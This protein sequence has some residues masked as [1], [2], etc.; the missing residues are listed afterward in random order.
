MGASCAC[1]CGERVSHKGAYRK[2]HQPAGTPRDPTGK[3]KVINDRHN[4]INNPLNNAKVQE[5]AR[6][7]AEERIAKMPKSE[8]RLRR[9]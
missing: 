9:P 7:E 6:E 8:P 2:G 4:P 3:S 1:G 5:R